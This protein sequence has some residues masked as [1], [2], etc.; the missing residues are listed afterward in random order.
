MAA[1]MKPLLNEGLKT[2]FSI[3]CDQ[4]FFEYIDEIV[5]DASEFL[6]SG[7]LGSTC[8]GF[9][10]GTLKPKQAAARCKELGAWLESKVVTRAL[11]KIGT[12]SAADFACDL[13]DDLAVAAAIDLAEA[14]IWV[15]MGKEQKASARAM[16][17]ADTIRPL[18]K[19]LAKKIENGDTAEDES[20]SEQFSN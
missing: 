20:I 9:H 13:V 8:E 7:N 5:E 14:I 17:Y 1:K 4:V 3:A 18:A 12:E 10:R 16:V 6:K 15:A 19:K 11:S 2:A